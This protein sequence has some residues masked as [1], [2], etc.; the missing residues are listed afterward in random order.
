MINCKECKDQIKSMEYCNNCIAKNDFELWE[1]L[2]K[3]FAL[4]M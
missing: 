2:T 3:Q 4:T 1:I